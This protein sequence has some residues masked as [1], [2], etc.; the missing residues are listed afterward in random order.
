MNTSL[1]LGFRHALHAVDARFKVHF[2]ERAVPVDLYDGFLHTALHAFGVLEHLDLPAFPL[3]VPR[4][5]AQQVGGKERGLI[6]PGSGADLNDAR[7]FAEWIGRNEERLG[8]FLEPG[9]GFLGALDFRT[10]FGGEFGVFGGNEIA[11]LRQ[12]V[13]APGELVRQLDDLEKALVLATEGRPE[14]CVAEGPGVA[15]FLLN[16]GG[17]FDRRRETCADAQ[18][19]FFPPTAYFCRKRSTRPAVSTSFC[20]PV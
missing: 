1:R 9:D 13:V 4:I 10:R 5:H 11:R 6:A 17:P 8:L 2:S 20:L 7:T 18:V 3:D 19:V 12:F 16:G 14:L 15:Q